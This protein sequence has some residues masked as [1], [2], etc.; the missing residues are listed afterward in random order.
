MIELTA[1]LS[2]TNLTVRI[3]ESASVDS[4]PKRE[5][6]VSIKIDWDGY[7]KDSGYIGSDFHLV[8]WRPPVLSKN[9]GGLDISE[10]VS[11]V[12]LNLENCS[13]S[14]ATYKF[15]KHDPMR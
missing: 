12:T 2:E 10:R 13:C 11:A 15:A 6:N 7:W 14:H 8:S 5:K 1:R 9:S 4:L 3:T